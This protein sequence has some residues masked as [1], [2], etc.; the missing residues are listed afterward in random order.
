M[1][2]LSAPERSAERGICTRIRAKV[3]ALGGCRA[4]LNRVEGWGNV[5]C[6]Q[7][8][9]TFPRCLTTPGLSFEPDYEKLKGV[10]DGQEHR[11]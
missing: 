2:E 4:C 6:D 10:K 7:P 11:S 3:Y 8:H 5:A 1:S 9:R